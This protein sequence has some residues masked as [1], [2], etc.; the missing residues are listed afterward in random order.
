L[1]GGG[2]RHHWGTLPGGDLEGWNSGQPAR[3]GTAA[4]G[5][6][7]SMGTGRLSTLVSGITSAADLSFQLYAESTDGLQF[8]SRDTTTTANRP[9]LV[10]T[11]ST[12]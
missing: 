12:S 1:P 7:P 9:Q 11:I 10:L 2:D 8:A 4:V 6:F 3:T 5:N